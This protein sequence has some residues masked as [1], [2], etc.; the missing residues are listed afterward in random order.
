[1]KRLFISTGEVSGDLQGALLVEALRRQA[2]QRQLDLEIVALG[3][4]RMAAAGAKLIGNTT[5]IGS[6]GLVESLPYVI[7]T[8]LLQRHTK[9]FLQANLPDMAV[10]IDYMTPNIV[11]GN[12]LRQQSKELPIVFYIAP[13]EWVW[14]FGDGN[15]T[16]IIK[17]VDEILAIFPGEARYYQSKGAA[18][19]YVGHPLVDRVAGNPDRATARAALG[20]GAD[21]VIIA[22]LPASRAQEMKYLL[23][24]IFAAA[25]QLQAEDGRIQ[26]LIPLA[27]EKYRPALTA[28][29]AQYGLRAKII[30]QAQNQAIAAA[31]LAITKSGT[32]NLEIALQNV[33]QVVIYR[34]NAF[35]A[36]FFRRVLRFSIPFMSPPNLINMEPVVP[37]LMQEAATPERIYAEAK[38]LLGGS[39]RAETLAGYARMREALGAPGACDRAA[40]LI[41]DRLEKTTNRPPEQS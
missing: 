16:Q 28:A 12:Y 8:L 18:V 14:S 3:G 17:F 29:I 1:M 7:P 13:Q 11:F 34:L 33:P 38:A 32:A 30:D 20:I 19:T 41:L 15:T 6:M 10:M 37:E 22:L 21:Q 31:D 35:T 4:D 40:K 24:P 27:L 5:A 23:P 2:K 9:R 39:Q 26:F 36:W 25:Q